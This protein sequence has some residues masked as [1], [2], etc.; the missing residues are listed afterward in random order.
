M[1]RETKPAD[2]KRNVSA[3]HLFVIHADGRPFFYLGDTVWELFHRLN[4]EEADCYLENRAR[5][6]CPVIQAMVWSK[7]NG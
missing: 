6:G 2:T 7:W 3:N 4:C 1:A 5:K